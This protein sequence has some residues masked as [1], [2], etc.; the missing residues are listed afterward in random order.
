MSSTPAVCESAVRYFGLLPC[1]AIE[2]YD[3][4]RTGTP[5]DFRQPDVRQYPQTLQTCLRLFSRECRQYDSVDVKRRA[6][7]WNSAVNPVSIN[8]CVQWLVS[9]RHF[10]KT[11]VGLGHL[12]EWH[13]RLLSEVGLENPKAAG[14]EHQLRVLQR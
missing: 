12:S 3:R 10:E 4:L 13:E 5:V 11:I 7:L 2:V 14:G 1:A 9:G 8:W 6:A